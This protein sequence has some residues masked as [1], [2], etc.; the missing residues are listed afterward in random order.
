MSCCPC[1]LNNYPISGATSFLTYGV[2]RTLISNELAKFLSDVR[3]EREKEIA[4]ISRH[5][6]I[7]L[8]T[9]I[10]KVNL[11]L[12]DLVSQKEAGSKEQ[13]IEGRL[14][15]FEDRVFELTGRL[16][17]RREELRKEENLTISDIQLIGRAWVLPHPERASATFAGM[18]RD[19]EIER[20][21]VEAVMAAER[22]RGWV[23]ESVESENRGFDLISRRPHKEDPKTF[24]EVRFIE[25]KGRA[26]VGDVALTANEFKTA[27]RL[28][29][30]YWL[31]V[32]YNCATSP[33]VHTV[34]DPSRMGWKPI[35][36]VE[37]YCVNSAAVLAAVTQPSGET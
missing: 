31:Y 34:Q 11:Q 2:E 20:I 6:E 35:V 27:E 1:V 10:D 28:K 33:Q 15:Q 12:G 30:D 36:K 3:A 8:N 21:A 18:V 9:I 29:K 13:G 19:T 25:V 23:V 17:R 37:H 5:M 14:K 32:V 22:A 26:G 4:T 16:E 24:I 7:S